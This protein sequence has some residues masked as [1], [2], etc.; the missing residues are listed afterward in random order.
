MVDFCGIKIVGDMSDFGE[1]VL[2]FLHCFGIHFAWAMA[3]P[4]NVARGATPPACTCAGRSG[5]RVASVLSA[6]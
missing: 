4:S 3:T 6:R 5:M 1:V 2:R